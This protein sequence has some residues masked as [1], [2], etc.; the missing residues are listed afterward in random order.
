MAIITVNEALDLDK[1][2]LDAD[3]LAQVAD[4]TR[5]L[6]DVI[7]RA[8]A[9]RNP[10]GTG[11]W[12]P[13]RFMVLKTDVKAHR[14]GSGETMRAVAVKMLA[15][16]WS[17]DGQLFSSQPKTKGGAAVPHHWTLTIVPHGVAYAAREDLLPLPA[18]SAPALDA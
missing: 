2:R 9:H 8:I 5:E 7:R 12:S 10:D 15:A 11:G 3:A 13:G 1:K 14:I 18:P 6:D 16:G 4:V 17:V